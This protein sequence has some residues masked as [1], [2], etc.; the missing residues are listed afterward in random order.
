MHNM[1][2]LLSICGSVMA[3]FA[4]VAFVRS[5]EFVAMASTGYHRRQATM[6]CGL[7]GL[8]VSKS[9]TSPVPGVRTKGAAA[10]EKR[11]CVPSTERLLSSWSGGR[12]LGC[13]KV[14]FIG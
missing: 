13:N 11:I 14:R 8:R 10:R 1:L 9:D 12:H 5:R 3:S 4:F 6:L 7:K 2:S